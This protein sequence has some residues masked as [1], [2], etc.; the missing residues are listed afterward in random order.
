MT[1]QY[2]DSAGADIDLGRD[3]SA[4]DANLQEQDQQQPEQEEQQQQPAPGIDL[5]TLLRSVVRDEMA[6]FKNSTQ[7]INDRNYNTLSALGQRIEALAGQ[8]ATVTEIRDLV[9]DLHALSVD[10]ND[11][12]KRQLQR[13]LAVAEAAVAAPAQTQ[14]PQQDE[15]RYAP[16]DAEWATHLDALNAYA[17]NKG[18]SAEELNAPNWMARLH[19]AGL[20]AVDSYKDIRSYTAGLRAAM[21]AL[22]TKE[23]QAKRPQ[24]RQTNVMATG[25]GRRNEL[26][27]YHK[28][29]R[30]GTKLPSPEEIDRITARILASNG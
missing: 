25:A 16:N 19:G 3:P 2:T 18:F 1:N 5:A 11:R 10:P 12:E 17:V 6:A 13:K 28:A 9:D 23:Y 14:Q 20:A 24:N 30:D 8:G 22:A 27:D 4:E 21:D 26:D 29:L 15:G 7:S